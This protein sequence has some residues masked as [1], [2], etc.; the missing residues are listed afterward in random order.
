MI[1]VLKRDLLKIVVFELTR[2][3]THSV[4]NK[5]NK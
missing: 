1:K 5:S 2:N 3:H 4:K